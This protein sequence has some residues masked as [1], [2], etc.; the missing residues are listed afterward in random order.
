MTQILQLHQLH[1]VYILSATADQREASA[2]ALC[3]LSLLCFWVLDHTASPQALSKEKLKSL[4]FPTFNY[5]V[6]LV[7]KI[8]ICKVTIEKNQASWVH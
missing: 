6:Y 3:N 7:G 1:I 5:W 8:F 4:S 2:S